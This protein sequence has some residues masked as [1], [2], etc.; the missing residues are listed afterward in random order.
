MKNDLCSCVNPKQVSIFYF[1]ISSPTRDNPN[2]MFLNWTIAGWWHLYDVSFHLNV[3]P[4]NKIFDLCK[5][6]A[7][8]K[9]RPLRVCVVKHLEERRMFLVETVPFVHFD[10]PAVWFTD[11]IIL[12]SL[13]LFFVSIAFLLNATAFDTLAPHY[14][15]QGMWMV[16]EW[17]LCLCYGAPFC[18]ETPWVIHAERSLHRHSAGSPIF[19]AFPLICWH[20]ARANAVFSNPRLLA[21]S[22]FGPAVWMLWWWHTAG[23]FCLFSI[24]MWI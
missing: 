1:R 5:C 19:L 16:I 7:V 17:L 4:Q 24:T 22:R 3:F 23:C 15:V 12:P 20:W 8:A 10:F 2:P 18:C 21:S 9:H 6:I 13:A 14:Q 11:E